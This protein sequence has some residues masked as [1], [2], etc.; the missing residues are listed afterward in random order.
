MG[1]GG[2]ENRC[3]RFQKLAYLDCECETKPFLPG[4]KSVEYMAPFCAAR[5][6]ASCSPGE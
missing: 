3:T 1:A 2:G 6:G 4:V 5:R